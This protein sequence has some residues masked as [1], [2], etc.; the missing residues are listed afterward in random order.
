[1]EIILIKMHLN[2]KKI[3]KIIYFIF[4]PIKLINFLFYDQELEI[5]RNESLLSK[6][7]CDIE[8]ARSR[9]SKKVLN[10]KVKSYHGTIIFLLD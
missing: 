3:T 2:K 10:I 6:L 9:L 4:H 7:G 8:K 1:M 5:K